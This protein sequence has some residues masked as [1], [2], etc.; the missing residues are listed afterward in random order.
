MGSLRRTYMGHPPGIDVNGT[1]GV[2][3]TA[4][5]FRLGA[6]RESNLASRVASFVGKLPCHLFSVRIT[7]AGWG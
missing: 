6:R 3:L 2:W 4:E 1:G 7:S 5:T